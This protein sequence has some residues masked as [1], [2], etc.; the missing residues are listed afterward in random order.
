ML[1]VLPI[2]VQTCSGGGVL[3]CT[4]RLWPAGS[5]MSGCSAAHGALA[6]GPRSLRERFAK[7]G[8]VPGQMKSRGTDGKLWLGGWVGAGGGWVWVRRGHGKDPPVV[9]ACPDPSAPRGWCCL[10]CS[11]LEADLRVVGSCS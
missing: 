2:P 8:P 10:F 11:I 1:L 7:A 6:T 5:G 3:H 9:S 4:M